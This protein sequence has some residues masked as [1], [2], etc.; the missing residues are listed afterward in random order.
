MS[1]RR[2]REALTEIRDGLEDHAS[3]EPTMMSPAE[4]YA[5]AADALKPVVPNQDDWTRP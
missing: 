1:C 5:I 2:M 4:V 3:H